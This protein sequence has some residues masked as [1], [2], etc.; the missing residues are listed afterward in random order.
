MYWI[1]GKPVNNYLLSDRSFQYGDGCF[2]TLLTRHGEIQY[3]RYHQERL[4]AALSAL[5]IPVP[6]W[7][8]V[9]AWLT[10]ACL[11]DAW[12][13]LKIHISRGAGGR[14]YSPAGLN[15][16]MIT[17][18]AFPY[19]DHYVTWQREGIPLGL[20]SM[21]LGWN[22]VLAGHKHNNRL[23]QVLAKAEMDRMGFP[24]GVT[25]DIAGHVVE[26]TMANL[27]WCKAGRCYTPQVDKAGVAGVMRRVV[28]SQ[29][30]KDDYPTEIGHYSL[31]EL[32]LADEIFI[33]NSIMGVVP[34]VQITDTSFDVGPLCQ[35]LKKRVIEC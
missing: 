22:P 29:L 25:L 15:H 35:Y 33:T 34:V 27:F 32:L 23:E 5:L 20:V 30:T 19:P 18:S 6:D 2:S 31:Q 17:I 8:Q 13:G 14:G 11:A 3:W 10:Q 28:L 7:E 26:T 4:T 1:N 24:D 12:A 9:Y 21:P 16:P